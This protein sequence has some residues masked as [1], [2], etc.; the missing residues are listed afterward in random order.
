MP[1]GILRVYQPLGDAMTLT[2]K[3]EMMS[4]GRWRASL[5]ELPH[6]FYSGSTEEAV[7]ERMDRLIHALRSPHISIE[8]VQEDGDVVLTLDRDDEEQELETGRSEYVS[9]HSPQMENMN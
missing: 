4:D 3:T 9:H 5:V 6:I 1:K 8:R 2:M 7:V